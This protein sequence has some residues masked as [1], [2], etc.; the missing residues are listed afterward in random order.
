MKR[1]AIAL[2]EATDRFAVLPASRVDP[3]EAVATMTL[4]IAAWAER[5][6]LN[7]LMDALEETEC[8]DL[9]AVSPI[10]RRQYTISR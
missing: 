8:A 6:W 7:G 1:Y 2:D 4:E 3:E 5:D 10:T 9:R